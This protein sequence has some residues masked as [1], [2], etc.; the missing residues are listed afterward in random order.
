MRHT[1]SL[2][3][4]RRSFLALSG[5]GLLAACG[6]RPQAETVPTASIVPASEIEDWTSISDAEWRSRLDK[7]QYYVLR[8]EG[9]ERSFTSPLNDE[10]RPG[11][12]HCAGCDLALFDA[13]TKYDSR[14]GWPSFWDH[15]PGTIDTKPDNKL[16]MQR[17]EY[18]CMRC[19][20][21]QGHVFGD[22]PRPTGLRYC[23]NGVALTF[24][25][26]AA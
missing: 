14:T 7:M 17:T 21:H 5:A 2:T 18:H 12:Y 16:W 20:G 23:N 9:T 15:I 8:E 13:S 11:V 19:K 10:K 24:R 22:G 26:A 4:T 3:P 25:P 6:A 1:P